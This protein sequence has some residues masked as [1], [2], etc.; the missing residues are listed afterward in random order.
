M[1]NG[2]KSTKVFWSTPDISRRQGMSSGGSRIMGECLQ[3]FCENISV[4]ASWTRS[5]Q[6]PSVN[7]RFQWTHLRVTVSASSNIFGS[8]AQAVVKT[9]LRGATYFQQL[10]PILVNLLETGVVL[11]LICP[12]PLES[13]IHKYDWNLTYKKRLR[14]FFQH[15]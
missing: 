12:L 7:G 10:S 15:K 13:E 11:L 8:R 2:S 1:S 14:C 9:S 3:N 4:G 6:R 5:N